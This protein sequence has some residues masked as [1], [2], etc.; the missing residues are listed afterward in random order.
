MVQVLKESVRQEILKC[1]KNKFLHKGFRQTSMSQ[2][3]YEANIT[4][5]NI[6]R[7]FKNKDALFEE[8]I[9]PVIERYNSLFE[10]MKTTVIPKACL[11]GIEMK[12]YDDADLADE[13]NFIDSHRDEFYLLFFCASGSKREK[14]VEEITEKI[15]QTNYNY[16]QAIK[17]KDPEFMEIPPSFMNVFASLKIS[18]Y[19][20]IIRNNLSKETLQNLF[21][22]LTITTQ[23]GWQGLLENLETTTNNL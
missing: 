6:Y 17:Q 8:L 2:I 3:A 1:A 21:E 23:K 9:R 22:L 13:I 19:K 7:Y 4:A 16:F 10:R 5:A 20:E 11:L 12:K 18:L 14:F 15:S